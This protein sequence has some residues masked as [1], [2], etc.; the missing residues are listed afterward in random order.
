[1]IFQHELCSNILTVERL[2]FSESLFE[3]W[4]CKSNESFSFSRLLFGQAKIPGIYGKNTAFPK[5]TV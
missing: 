1:M 3:A 5:K 4:Q 2:I